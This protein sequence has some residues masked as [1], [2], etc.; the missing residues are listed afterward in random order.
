ME[1]TAKIPTKIFLTDDDADDCLLFSEA[2]QEIFPQQETQPQSFHTLKRTIAFV[3]SFDLG[4]L[5]QQPLRDHFV[6]NLA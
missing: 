1:S 2:L 6:I 4:K 5:S 3:L